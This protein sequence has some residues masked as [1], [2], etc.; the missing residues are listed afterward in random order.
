MLDALKGAPK[1]S[2]LTWHL[3]HNG[4][5]TDREDTHID[6]VLTDIKQAASE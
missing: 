5:A 4:C 3:L 2:P 6:R 1:S